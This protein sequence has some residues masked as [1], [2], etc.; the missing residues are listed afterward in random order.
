MALLHLEPLSSRTRKGDLLRFLCEQGGLD[1]GAVG[2][3]DIHGRS[4]TVEVPDGRVAGLLQALDGASLH[5]RRLRAWCSGGAAS[6]DDHFTRLAELLELESQ[7]ETRQVVERV[8]RLPPAEA[9]ASGLSLGD[10]VV[11]DGYP[12]LGGRFLLALVKRDRGPLPWTRL[13]AGSPVVLSPQGQGADAGWRGVVCEREERLLR[14]AFNEP[15]DEDGAAPL[16]RL[17]LAPDEA[18]RLRQRQALERARSAQRERLA[19]LRAV[20]LGEAEPAFGAPPDDEPLSPALNES[21]REAVRFALSAADLAVIHGPPGTGKTTTV[22]ELVRRAVRRGEKV[23]VCAPS[24][25]A[26]D[27]VLERLLAHGENAVRLG[28]PARVLPQLRRHTLDLLVEHHADARQARKLVKEAF[29]LFRQA[30]KW[31]RAKPEPGARRD[32]RQEARALLADARRLEALAVERVLDRAPILCSTTTGLDSEVVGQRR[33]DLLVLDEAC[34][35]TEPGCWIPLQRAGRVVLA[36]DHCQL[37]PTVLSPEA[38]RQGFGV[39]LLERLVGLYGARVTRRLDVQYRMHED[40]MAFSSRELYEGAL[41]ADDSVKGHRLCDLPGVA[42][43]PLTEAPVLFVD[44]AGAGY[45]EEQEPDGESRLNPREAD[46]VVRKVRALLAAG[47]RAEDVGVIAP[48]SA[49]VRRLRRDLAEPGLEVDS[50][51]GFQGREKEAVVLSL[52]RS[53]SEGEIGFLADVRRTNVALTRARRQLL[54]VGDSAT[55]SVLPFY[56]RL[57]EHFEALGAYHTVW[58]EDVL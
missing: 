16:Y 52:V 2:R 33:F 36:G 30:G 3:I 43:G 27:N 13:Q 18:A 34:Q 9:E 39:S 40:I 25:L 58:E 54:V 46:L 19:E 47:V 12:G 1:R 51:D 45:E 35:T 24:N 29:G 7:A 5:D 17:D 44:T 38:Q 32:M 53:N 50:V 48:Y 20:L 55:L 49:Q 31:T 41:R 11:Q 6:P 37:P 15:P 57:F 56:R 42:P 28:H 21:Q 23:L 22:V 14:V 26:V 8:Q 10:L 4:A